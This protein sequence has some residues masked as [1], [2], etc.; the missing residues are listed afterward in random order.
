MSY[1]NLN[2]IIELAE[3]QNVSRAAE[4]LFIS[5]SALSIY[6]KKLESE[7][8]VNLFLRQNNKLIPTEKG[9]I[10]ISTA[11]EIL[12]LEN[13]M[14]EQ[15]TPHASSPVHFGIASELA[16]EIFSNVYLNFQKT[17]PTFNVSLIDQRSDYLIDK[18]NT[19]V[20]D[21]IIT[22]KPRPL[23]ENWMQCNLLKR[24]EMVLVI[25]P[26]HPRAY[27]ASR[28]YDDPPV[29]DISLFQND[30]FIVPAI[31]TVDYQLCKQVFTDYHMEPE[32][33]WAVNLLY[34]P[35]KMV[36]KGTCLTIQPGFTVPRNMDILVCKPDRPYFRYTQLIHK[37]SRSPSRDEQ[38]LLKQIKNAYLHWYDDVTPVI[39]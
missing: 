37:K 11:R 28:N 25:P 3:Q 16:M 33:F 35:F 29:A 26:E 9:N 31:D 36:E 38:L 13:E 19:G 2:Y 24:E 23:A 18:L 14:Y 12:R 7:L 8:G 32:I 17:H 34:Q 20:L 30:K 1:K 22:T 27:L 39:P 5:Q 10:V 6:L 21:F 4:K 15:L